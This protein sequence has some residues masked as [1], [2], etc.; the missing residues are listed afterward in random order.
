MLKRSLKLVSIAV[1]LAIL[2]VGTG[3]VVLKFWL[4]PKWVRDKFLRAVEPRWDGT[5][6]AGEASFYFLAPAQLHD[7]AFLD[8]QDRIWA[9]TETVFIEFEEWPAWKPTPQA[10]WM[11]T[12]EVYLYCDD[13]PKVSIPVLK[14]DT[15][16]TGLVGIQR[17]SMEQVSFHLVDPDEMILHYGQFHLT[18]DLDPQRIVFKA[19][20]QIV[21]DSREALHAVVTLNLLN[22][23]Y[24]ANVKLHHRFQEEELALVLPLLA[25]GSFYRGRGIVSTDLIV[26]GNLE[27]P[28]DLQAYGDVFFSE[29]DVLQP[30]GE[31]LVDDFAGDLHIAGNHLYSPGMALGF[32][33]AD[34]HASVEADFDGL[35]PVSMQGQVLVRGLDLEKLSHHI[36]LR[37]GM[38][39]GRID[40]DY[41]FVGTGPDRE[42]Y[43]G[44][45]LL[46]MQDA[47][48][49]ASRIM[50]RIFELL[51]LSERN[52]LEMSDGFAV[53]MTHGTRIT[54]RQGQVSN[55]LAAI[56]VEPGGWIDIL[57]KR[58][59]LYVI[60]VPLKV[61]QSVLQKI[62]LVKV[63]VGFKDKLNRVRVEGDYA[64]SSDKL[65]RKEVLEDIK[66]GLVQGIVDIAQSGGEL[67]DLMIQGART[68]FHTIRGSSSAPEEGRNLGQ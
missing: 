21:P 56:L 46:L 41:V 12:A 57:D 30:S 33:G 53:F 47:N 9:R 58:V 59:D 49:S 31:I 17:C 60:A 66:E 16:K 6:K 2:L 5:V 22:R 50:R 28:S 68:F 3:G 1:F 14:S 48:L 45:G 37:G 19:D 10:I 8:R 7:V 18:A 35:D 25:E 27:K 42:E 40:L 11:E 43:Y 13:P 44:Y 34:I 32:C 61:V 29:W 36:A 67:T 52:P 4:G 63:L 39:R 55:R 51:G 38:D 20:R 62:P 54:I 15:D 64:D 65:V 26:N 23:D 24:E